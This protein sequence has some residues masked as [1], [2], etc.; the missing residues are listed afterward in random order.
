MATCQKRKIHFR[1]LLLTILVVVPAVGAAAKDTVYSLDNGMEVILRENHSSPMIASMIFV[2]S[3]SKYESKYENGITHFLEHLLF[4]GTT[5]L[6]REELDASIRDLGGML[7]AFTREEMTCYFTLLPRQYNDYGL[8]V[9]ADML[10]NS[11]FPEEELSKERKVVAEEINRDADAPAAPKDAFFTE[12]AYSGTDYDRP[13]LG[14]KGFIENIPRAAIVDY[15]KRYYR[16]ENMVALI[17]GDFDTEQMKASM[18]SIFGSIVDTVTANIPE[19]PPVADRPALTGQNVYD[20]V[21]NVKSTYINFSIAAP[22]HSEPDH[23][24][25]DLL[26][27]YLSMDEIS[28]LM[29]ALKGGEQPLATEVYV[30]LATR[31]EFSRMEVSVITDNADNADGIVTTVLEQLKAVPNHIADNESLEGIKTSVKTSDIYNSE[32]L[33]FVA[34]MIGPRMMISG[35]ESVLAYPD[36]LAE[37]QWTNCQQ[38]AE[39][40]LVSPN[41]VATVVKPVGDG[42]AE[43]Y[44]PYELPSEEVVAH[45]D[46]VQFAAFDLQNG[47]PLTFPSTD[48]VSLEYSDP[49]EYHREVL[50]NGLT[51]IIRSNPD[52]RV[53]GMNI[54]GKNRTANEPTDKIGIT[55]FVNRCLDK[56]TVT[57]DAS[58]L[59]RDLAKIGANVTLCDNPWIPYDDRYTT[60]QYS[61]MKFETID[62]FA[63]RG[64]HLFS[65]MILYP[66]FDPIEVENVRRSMMGV[67]GRS[68]GSPSKV[69]RDGFFATLFE[70]KEYAHPI[71]GS[72]RTLG[73]ITVDD[74]KAHHAS[75]YSPGNMILSITTNLPVATVKD[76]VDI[77][78]GRLSYPPFES[79]EAQSPERLIETR[80]AHTELDKEQISIYLGCDLPG[81]A[82]KD[83][84]LIRVAA[85][86]L[87]NRLYLNL[88]EKQGLAYSVGAGANLDKNFGWFYSS[89]TTAS[90][91]YQTAFDGLLLQTDKLR[92]DGPTAEEVSSAKNQ[93]L[94]SRMRARLSS[95]NQA[96]YLG[97]NEYLG[98]GLNYDSAF[99]AALQATDREAVRRAAEKYFRSDAYVLSTAGKKP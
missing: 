9:L 8:T 64:F 89:I 20:T 15:W 4:D 62:E 82:S 94:G 79:N 73:G 72:P 1:A 33:Y 67:L 66:S 86:I 80:V 75:F 22:H 76:W 87:S 19:E 51:V 6:T 91:N 21:A 95:V 25:M 90:Q 97:V 37:V 38:I 54:I 17:I 43:P 5:H 71:M 60:R 36:E 2:K 11:V 48:S 99:L 50:A 93:I 56:G 47:Y 53:F 40:W 13:V 84:V 92:F 10:F 7:N 24:A 65:D 85:T 77:R 49:A 41:Y 32:K 46:S 28:P 31:P 44:Q 26:A 27:Q 58:E 30:T 18:A 35:W 3:G 52:T 83:A 29:I 16:P 34:F 96:Y 59:S 61:F 45:F 88:R 81:V 98:R 23:L 74:L 69:A 55:D 14:Y 57:R 63:E 12:K 70:G 78:F 39:K 68:S 42:A